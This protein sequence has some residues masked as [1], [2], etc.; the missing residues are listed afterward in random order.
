MVLPQILAFA[1][2]VSIVTLATIGLLYYFDNQNEQH[3]HRRAGN[4]TA[5]KTETTYNPPADEDIYCTICLEEIA[6]TNRWT[7]PC[8]HSFHVQCL[9]KWMINK[10]VCPNCRKPI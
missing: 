6:R 2:T 4:R 3:H 8:K 1:A 10:Q 9:N 7:L 5:R